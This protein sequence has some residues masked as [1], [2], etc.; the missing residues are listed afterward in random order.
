MRYQVS[1]VFLLSMLLLSSCA[2]TTN[3]VKD[4]NKTYESTSM[5]ASKA[6]M[7][8]TANETQKN[9]ISKVKRSPKIDMVAVKG[10]CFQMGD[11]FGNGRPDE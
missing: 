6:D 7:G 3:P 1:V 8:A 9:N 5:Q 2:T 4:T 11:T 10:R